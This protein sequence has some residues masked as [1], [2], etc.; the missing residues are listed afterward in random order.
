[1]AG[2][3]ADRDDEIFALAQAG[4]SHAEIAERYGISRQRVGLVLADMTPA[5]WGFTDRDRAQIR[6]R[7]AAVLER[8]ARKV[9]AVIDS[10]PLQHS[11]I[12][13]PIEDPRNPGT[14]LVNES[15]R[16]AAI[17]ERRLL[18]ESFRRL[19]GADLGTGDK[20]M[21]LEDAQRAML[22][23]I[24]RRRHEMI[25]LTAATPQPG[26]DDITDAEPTD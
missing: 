12:G 25:A 3:N 4:L 14:Y 15:V 17:R 8:M 19:T 24:A 11:A 13:K 22:A 5:A 16:V 20:T 6:A 10:A 21:P 26:D 2:D 23:D 9:E 7:E 1:V 18:S